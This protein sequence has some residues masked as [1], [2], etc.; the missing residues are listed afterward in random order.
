M[1]DYDA[2]LDFFFREYGDVADKDRMAIY[3]WSFG[4]YMTL[5]MLLKSKYEFRVGVAGGAV[6]DW[7]YYEVMYTER[8]MGV[9]N[10][11][12]ESYYEACDIK[13]DLHRL[14]TPLCLIHCNH[15]NVV[16]DIHP[17]SLLDCANKKCKNS[18][19]IEYYLFFGH[20]HNVT[21]TERLELMH[22]VESQ[23]EKYIKH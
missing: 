1:K 7:R 4:G 19:L 9:R 18:S 21:G 10:L 22:K 6:V 13:H 23:I 3:G 14:H 8:Y 16:L 15:D 2:A 17:A 11:E 20:G 12:N 5:S